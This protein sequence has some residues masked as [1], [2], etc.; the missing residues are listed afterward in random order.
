MIESN[1]TSDS[2]EM[3]LENRLADRKLMGKR[4]R[5]EIALRNLEFATNYKGY[6][7][8]E[9]Y[10]NNGGEV[11]MKVLALDNNV[12]QVYSNKLF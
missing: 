7:Q 4:N 1:I 10:N 8:L 5:F 11:W 9:F 2:L 3:A 12:K 6:V